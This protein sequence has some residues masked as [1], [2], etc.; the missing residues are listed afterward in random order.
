M[1]NRKKEDNTVGH[2]KA[3]RPVII[4]VMLLVAALTVQVLVYLWVISQFADYTVLRIIVIGLGIACAG[5]IAAVMRQRTKEI[6]K[7][8]E[9]DLGNY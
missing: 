5:M 3:L 9:N 4:T 1:N 8:E 6:H 7:G 2:K